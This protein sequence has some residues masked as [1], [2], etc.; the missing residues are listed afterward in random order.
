MV[1]SIYFARIENKMYFFFNLNYLK[2]K[3]LVSYLHKSGH[4]FLEND[5]AALRHRRLRVDAVVV[6]DLAKPPFYG[7]GSGSS[8]SVSSLKR[9]VT[10]IIL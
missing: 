3:F 6:S 4:L 5:D 2:K 10:D 1:D 7:H 9:L 8:F